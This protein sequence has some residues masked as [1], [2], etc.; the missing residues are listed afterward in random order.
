MIFYHAGGAYTA[1]SFVS[2]MISVLF[3]HVLLAAELVGLWFTYRKMNL[4]GW[5]GIIPFYNV[6][7]MFEELWEVKYFWRTIIYCVVFIVCFIPGEIMTVLGSVYASG[8][9]YNSSKDNTAV[10]LLII[11]VALLIAALVMLIL[12]LVIYFK[13]YLKI[14]RAFGLKTAW[15]W[16]M[17]F[18]PYIIFPIIGFNKK[19]VYYGKINHI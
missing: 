12:S 4:P 14:A 7:I 5:K 9:S 17:L 6:Y 1:L 2:T 10:I 3:S 11:G 8:A 16:G 15:A 13:I 19:I 18:V